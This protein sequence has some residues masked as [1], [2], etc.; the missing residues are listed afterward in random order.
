MIGHY[1]NGGFAELIAVPA[2]NAL[3]LPPEIPFEQGATLMCAS[4]TAYHALRKSGLK[5]GETAAI[6]GVG[7]L[8]MSAVQLARYFGA[9]DVYAVDIREESL[10]LA[11]SYGAIPVDPGSGDPV[12]QIRR[13][14]GDRGVDVAVEMLGR[15]RTMRQAVQCLAPLGRAV[16]VGIGGEPLTLD[17]Y[18][19]I[20]GGEAQLI[21]SNDHL[22][23]ELPTVIELAR[24]GSLDISRVVTRTISLDAAAINEAIDSLERHGPGIRMVIV[25]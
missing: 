13:H 17:T 11:A 1:A 20:L 16:I 14:T 12:E 19:E 8:G 24:R 3:L 4:A 21:G 9:L 6:I 5:P 23:A 22:L 2:R 18:R 7:G 10:R 25:P 15:A